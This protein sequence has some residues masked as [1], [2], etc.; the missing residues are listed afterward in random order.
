M[1]GLIA[2][3]II[4]FVLAGAAVV[5]SRSHA[6]P[7]DTI[8]MG[9]RDYGEPERVCVPVDSALGRRILRGG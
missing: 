3:G 1:S 7:A 2:F 6:C 8:D 5:S 4:L 9:L